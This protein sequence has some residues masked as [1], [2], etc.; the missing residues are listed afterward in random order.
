MMV[1]FPCWFSSVALS[2]SLIRGAY[3]HQDQPNDL[4]LHERNP[5]RPHKD[6]VTLLEGKLL[7]GEESSTSILSGQDDDIV[8]EHIKR[9]TVPEVSLEVRLEEVVSILEE[10]PSMIKL[11]APQLGKFV[12]LILGAENIPE[13]GCRK[14]GGRAKCTSGE[15]VF[16]SC[17]KIQD[18]GA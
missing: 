4:L 17:D 14:D 15:L 11:D 16:I 1:R 6:L 10:V 12:V 8:L 7:V 9:K 18:G 5:H 13:N 3:G 2:T